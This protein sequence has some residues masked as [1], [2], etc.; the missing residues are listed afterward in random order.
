MN[1]FF[2]QVIY[3]FLHPKHSFAVQ[4]HN[5]LL[6]YFFTS[7]G[8]YYIHITIVND[9]SSIVNKFG[10]SLTDDARVIIYDPHMFIVQA[11]DAHFNILQC[12]FFVC[13]Y[14]KMMLLHFVIIK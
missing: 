13:E 11:T 1:F 12:L 9:A 7:Y 4:L 3:D 2:F 6:P 14:Y 8:L 10:T 5:A